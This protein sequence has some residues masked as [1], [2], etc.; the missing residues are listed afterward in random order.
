MAN[1]SLT[2]A[3]P[4]V[5]II[6]ITYNA[7]QTVERTILSVEEQDYPAIQYIVIDGGSTDGTM[8]VVGRHSKRVNLIVS[9]PDDGIYYAMNKGLDIATG[10]YVWFV[11]AGDEFNGPDAVSRAMANADGADI[12]YGDT[13]ITAMD[14]SIIGGRRLTPPETL[15]RDSFRDGMLVCHQAFI[16]RRTLCPHYDT[17]YRFSADYDWCLRII[18]KSRKTVNTH[19]TIVRFLDGGVTKSHIVDGLRERFRIMRQHY[20]LAPTVLRHIPI[21]IRFLWFWATKGRF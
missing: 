10:E 14:G 21:G 12:C 7:V 18:E 3:T 11:N 16:A 6:T 8:Q 1:D 9:E 5:S 4:I 19:E 17:Q 2:M 20:G 13:V 15:T